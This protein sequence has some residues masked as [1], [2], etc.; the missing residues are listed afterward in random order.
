[1]SWEGRVVVRA[2]F[3]LEGVSE[4]EA[5][6][7]V[8]AMVAGAEADEP[9]TLVYAWFRHAEDRSRWSVLEV[10]EDEAAQKRH[11]RGPT[12]KE[13]AKRLGPLIA[14]GGVATTLLGVAAKGIG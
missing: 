1:M 11:L 9:G 12:I 8:A 4:A 14:E 6:E 5:D 13:A 2:D 7:I 10:Y 3:S